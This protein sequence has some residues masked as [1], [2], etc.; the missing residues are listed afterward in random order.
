MTHHELRRLEPKRE[1][2]LPRSVCATDGEM[3]VP[4]VNRG[5]ERAC[6]MSL[7]DHKGRCCLTARCR[8]CG[9]RSRRLLW[10]VCAA[11]GVGCLPCCD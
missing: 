11:D 10:S 4:W 2:S 9:R 6:W 5:G 3:Y 7:S 8:H 1:W